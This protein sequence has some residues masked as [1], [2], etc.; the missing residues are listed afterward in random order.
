MLFYFTNWH[1]Y[2]SYTPLKYIKMRRQWK[3]AK[4]TSD[5]DV[6]SRSD[7]KLTHLA[8]PEG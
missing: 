2:G 3:G 5:D 1:G 7:V 6:I 8:Q 4:V